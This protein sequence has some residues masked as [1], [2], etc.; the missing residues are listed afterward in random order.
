MEHM[1]MWLG[2]SHVINDIINN[3][4]IYIYIYMVPINYNDD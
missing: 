2:M 3:I 1:A 4:H